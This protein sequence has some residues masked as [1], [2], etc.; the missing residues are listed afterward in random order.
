MPE[1]K[2]ERKVE[3]SSN[4]AED[5]RFLEN[6]L[7][8]VHEDLAGTVNEIGYQ[9]KVIKATKQYW[10]GLP[11]FS[12]EMA[13]ASGAAVLHTWREQSDIWTDRSKVIKSQILSASG[14]ATYFASTTGTLSQIYPVPQSVDFSA[15]KQ[16]TEERAEQ[17][18]VREQLIKIDNS[19]VNTYASIWQYMNYPAFDPIR[20]PLYLMRKVFDHFLGKMAPDEKVESQPGFEPNEKLKERNGKGIT[21]EHRI[22]YLAENKVLDVHARE[23]L[24]SSTKNFKDI[25]ESLNQAHN[26]G[27]LKEETA[28]QAVYSGNVLLANWLKEL[29]L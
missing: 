11:D 9:L 26:R 27:E 20:G 1:Q 28:R 16:V 21:R 6:N 15:I 19:L 23:A 14:T 5:I 13:T 10:N 25:Y 18:F 24:L 3:P 29:Q 4:P 7:N 12:S 22:K 8:R 17:S 2:D